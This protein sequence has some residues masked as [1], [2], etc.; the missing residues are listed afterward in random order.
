[1][2]FKRVG[3][4]RTVPTPFKNLRITK[5][6]NH[7]PL[8]TKKR[9]QA[10]L[11]T[12]AI[13][14]QV[15]ASHHIHLFPFIEMGLL[16]T[17]IKSMDLSI[18]NIKKLPNKVR[19]VANQNVIATISPFLTPPLLFKWGANKKACDLLHWKIDHYKGKEKP[20]QRGN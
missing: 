8:S 2:N 20:I 7:R 12:R 9:S 19:R 13:F 11:A 18:P 4:I 1:M 6:F 17:E 3:W 16:I 10:I 14:F 5:M 15:T